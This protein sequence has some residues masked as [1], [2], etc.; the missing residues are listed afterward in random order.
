MA[1]FIPDNAKSI[2][3]LHAENLFL[4]KDLGYE[5]LLVWNPDV[6]V[7]A[8]DASYTVDDVL[9]DE[10]LASLTAVIR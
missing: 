10:N 3:N 1:Q 2:N 7:I 5:Q 4:C 6:I 9:N 8:S